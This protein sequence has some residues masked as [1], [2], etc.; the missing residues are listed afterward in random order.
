[1][2]KNCLEKRS[3]PCPR[4]TFFISA[5]FRSFQLKNL[6]TNTLIYFVFSSMETGYSSTMK[7]AFAI[8]SSLLSFGRFLL[9]ITELC[10]HL[11]TVY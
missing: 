9:P 8:L 7:K 2:G 6:S 4:E 3:I 11:G 10:Q 1:M 5:E